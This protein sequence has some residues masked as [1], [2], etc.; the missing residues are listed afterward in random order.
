M[1]L[2]DRKGIAPMLIGQEGEPFDSDEYVF[3][4]KL[5]GERCLAYLDP[6]GGS[7]ISVEC[8]CY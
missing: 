3:E 7:S 4:L 8:E 5:D 6:A 1:D 2:F